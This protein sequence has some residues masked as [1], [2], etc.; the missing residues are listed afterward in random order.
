[1]TDK[2]ERIFRFMREEGQLCLCMWS[3]TTRNGV[4]KRC[5]DQEPS[6]LYFLN[7]VLFWGERNAQRCFP[8]SEELR[9]QE[10]SAV[11][12]RVCAA[13]WKAVGGKDLLSGFKYDP[14][15]TE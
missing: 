9:R 3:K 11:H 1:M 8:T 12:L 6:E 2:G 14:Q 10:T 15:P 4:R 5:V 13:C 7:L